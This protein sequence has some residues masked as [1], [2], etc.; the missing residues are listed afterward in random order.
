MNY[1]VDEF[2]TRGYKQM[3]Q[4]SDDLIAKKEEKLKEMRI[5]RW[6]RKEK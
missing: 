5:N 1:Q 3:V 4:I 6:K 2:K